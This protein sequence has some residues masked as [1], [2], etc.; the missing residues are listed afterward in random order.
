M[1]YKVRNATNN[2]DNATNNTDNATNNTDN[3]TNNTDNATNNTDNA[4]NTETPRTATVTD[5]VN[6]IQGEE[7]AAQT[8][9]KTKYM[10]M[11]VSVPQVPQQPVNQAL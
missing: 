3:A 10:M 5:K 8:K 1:T 4:N 6:D 7:F 2:A 11:G 9:D